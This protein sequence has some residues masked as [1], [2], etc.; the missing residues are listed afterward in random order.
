MFV[1]VRNALK[2]S[3]FNPIHDAANRWRITGSDVTPWDCANRRT[4][5]YSRSNWICCASVATPRS[6]P[7]SALATSQP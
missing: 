7:S 6:K 4:L 2:R 3:S 1:S 5:P